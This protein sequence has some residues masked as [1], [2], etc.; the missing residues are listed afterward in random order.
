MKNGI[1]ISQ[2][3]GQVDFA[4]V[5]ESGIEFVILRSGYRNTIDSRFLEYA[6]G[7]KAVNLH[8]PGT[9]HFSYALNAEEARKEALFAVANCK[10]AG[11]TDPEHVIF[12]DFEYDTVDKAKKKGVILGPVECNAH[13]KIFCETV[14][15]EGYKAGIYFNIDYYRNWYKKDLLDKY[16]KW[17]ADYSGSPDYPCDYQQTSSK[18]SIS[19]IVGNVDT[20]TF[21]GEFK[22][23]EETPTKDVTVDDILNTSRN[24]LGFNQL[25]GSFKEI[26]DLYN[27]HKPLAVGYLVK[28]TDQWCDA[29][30]SAVAIKAGAVDLIGTECGVERHVQIFKEKGI[31]IEDGRIRPEPGDIIVYNWD[32]DTQPNDGFSDHIGFVETVDGSTITLIEGNYQ[33]AVGRRVI[34]IG[35]GYIRGFA[36]PKYA[37]S[38]SVPESTPNEPKK[39]VNVLAKEV[40]AGL[41]GSGEDRKQR[42]RAAGHNYIEVQD[43]VNELL[44]GTPSK[45]TVER[46]AQ[47]V[48]AGKWGIGLDR[49]NRLTAAGYNYDA[50]QKKVNEML[51]A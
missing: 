17:L 33:K 18:G 14:E 34:P 48:I 47:E 41:W 12:F 40:I 36:R 23:G 11:L 32:D 9:Y 42:L 3:Q 37:P 4:K 28:Y 50:V 44:L 45:A 51:K 35:W 39:T 15:A 5:K 2:W 21:F 24:W 30:V 29:F 16:V 6:A 38:H 43:R 8:I 13:A 49:K 31:W 20:N 27:A 26:I 7:F 25:D 19:G 46:I 10:K 1:D 22:M